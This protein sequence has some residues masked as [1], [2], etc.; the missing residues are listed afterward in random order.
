MKSWRI[1]ISV[2]YL[3]CMISLT[4]LLG[5]AVHAGSLFPW[6]NEK[7]IRALLMQQ[8]KEGQSVACEAI[9]ARIAAR[10]NP[11]YFVLR[12]TFRPAGDADS[13]LVILGRVPLSLRSGQSVFVSGT[14]GRLPNNEPCIYDATV[15]G[16][17]DEQGRPLYWFAF[18]ELVTDANRQALPL[19]TG[20]I[21]P[22]DPSLFDDGMGIPGEVSAYATQ[23]ISRYETIASLIA[24]APA[25]LSLVELSAKPIVNINSGEGYIEVGDDN[26]D[27][28]IKVYTKIAVKP[29]DRLIRLTGIVHSEG[30][31]PVLYSGNGDP[32]FFDSQGLDAGSSILVASPGGVAYAASLRDTTPSEARSAVLRSSGVSTMSVHS[33]T[34][35]DGSWIYLTGQVVTA[36]GN[37]YSYDMAGHGWIPIYYIQGLDRTP[38]IRVVDMAA[39]TPSIS[40]G[41]IVDVMAKIDAKDGER[42]LGIVDPWDDNSVECNV[43]DSSQMLLP[44]PVS[45][46]N[47]ALGGAGMGN[48]PGIVGDPYG[49]YNIGSYVKIWGKALETG[50]YQFEWD[51]YYSTPYMRIDDGS[52]VPSGN[53]AYGGPYGDQGVIVFGTNTYDGYTPVN[54]GDYIA[55][56]GISSIWKPDGSTNTYRAIWT[57]NSVQDLTA[58]GSGSPPDDTG[59]ISGTVTLYDM[60]TSSAQVTL[61]STCGRMETLT[62]TDGNNDHIGTASYSWTG[63]PIYDSNWNTVYY[64]IS[65]KADGYKIRTYTGVTPWIETATPKNLYLVPARKIYLNT[66]ENRTYIGP[67]SPISLNIGA[68][69][70]DDN[71]VGIAYPNPGGIVRFATTAGSFNPTTLQQTITAHTN[72]NGAATVTLYGLRWAGY[73]TVTATDDATTPENTDPATTDDTY[74]C[75]WETLPS[76]ISIYAPTVYVN[77]SANPTV[78]ARCGSSYS[79]VTAHV[80]ICGDFAPTGSTVNFTIEEDDPCVFVSTG[81][82]SATANTDANGDASVQVRADDAHHY[83]TAYITASADVYAGSGTDYTS[84]TVSQYTT[85]IQASADPAEI[86]GPDTSAITFTATDPLNQNQP[87]VGVWL[88]IATSAGTFVGKTNPFDQQTDGNGIVTVTLSLNTARSAAITATYTD[89]CLGATTVGTQVLY[90]QTQWND[91]TIGVNYS[92]LLVADLIPGDGQEVAVIG[93]DGMIHVWNSDGSEAWTSDA[94][95]GEGN[96]TLS[97][98][99]IDNRGSLEMTAPGGSPYVHAFGYDLSDMTFKPLAGWP[100]P[101]PYAFTAVAAALGDSNLDGTTKVVAGDLSC[102]VSCWNAIG[103]TNYDNDPDY[104]PDGSP[105][106]VLWRQVTYSKDVSIEYSSVALGDVNPSADT[107]H[108]PDAIVG[109]KDAPEW[110]VWAFAGDSYHNYFNDAPPY[111]LAPGWGT[112][113]SSTAICTSPAIGDIDGDAH[114]DVVVAD[115]GGALWIWSGRPVSPSWTSQ[116]VGTAAI[117][118]SPVIANL[119]G[120][121]CVIFGCDDGRVYAVHSDFSP[122]AGWSGGILLNAA[123]PTKPIK[124]SPI[125]G[126]V[127]GTGQPQVVV[128]STDGNVYALWKDG[129]NHSGGPIA[130]IWTCVQSDWGQILATPAICTLS[131]AQ[132]SML[133]LVVGSTDGIYKMDLYSATFQP[134]TTRWPWP[135]F[136]HDNARTGCNNTTTPSLVSASVIGR[137]VTSGGVGVPGVSINIA[138]S[139]GG[140]G[141]PGVANRPGQARVDPVYTAGNSTANDE[142]NEGGFVINQLPVGLE[143]QYRLTFH[144]SG[145]PDKYRYISAMTAGLKTATDV[146]Y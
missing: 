60:T 130:E 108:I 107:L 118:S 131:N 29:R 82:K 77:A 84:V 139:A 12:D 86:T 30:G 73:A 70:L 76:T 79:T 51:S 4:T 64:M 40:P 135:T 57:A 61:C 42:L 43:L 89:T 100:T 66:Q 56:T 17:F 10:N 52:A 25:V 124:A 72:A 113:S 98:A 11:P 65:A 8:P 121:A 97:A 55:V 1:H 109:T 142:I 96:N 134:G 14:L 87:A 7:S 143:V 32:R 127:M 62:V 85:E 129:A 23:G 132:P 75:D 21:P 78:I 20:P 138:Y 24:S 105:R 31:Q 144:R 2:F 28:T 110:Q 81:T 123:S 136:H 58:S 104:D 91:I 99:D 88:H 19:P 117:W 80:T 120:Q 106:S 119:D 54:V 145:Y 94:I 27:S 47:K 53:S 45:M 16:F 37:Y 128:A 101:A 6:E 71:H 74:H 67:C 95:D 18:H 38:G 122:A 112:A 69:V 115:D 111:S 126:D 90:R 39:Y 102:V 48:N 83:G 46:V 13:K 44:C 116:T 49:L 141:T 41:S 133:S 26:S 15:E 103:S 50:S 34:T 125:V 5:S 35:P 68:T 36:V 22:S 33:P 92:S 9:V 146:V 137:A 114:N 3:V 140:T 93:S 59:T 63:V